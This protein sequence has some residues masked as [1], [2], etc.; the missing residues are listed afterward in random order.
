LS[1]RSEA[2]RSAFASTYQSIK[3]ARPLSDRMQI[4]FAP[5]S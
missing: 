2:E 3:T 4:A 1:S 5:A